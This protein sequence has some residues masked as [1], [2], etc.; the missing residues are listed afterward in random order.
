ME[1]RLVEVDVALRNVLAEVGVQRG[2][3]GVVADQPVTLLDVVEHRLPVDQQP[4]R[5]AEVAVVG[6][7]TFRVHREGQVPARRRVRHLGVGRPRDDRNRL[8]IDPDRDV[9]VAGEQRVDPRRGVTDAEA[10]HLVDV[11]IALVV[12]VRVLRREHADPGAEIPGG[13]AE[14]AGAHEVVEVL[15]AVRHHHRVHVAEVH[16]EVGVGR[17]EV[18]DEPVPVR[19]HVRDDVEPRLDDRV[20]LLAPVTVQRV[21]AVLDGQRLAVVELDAAADLESPGLEI[22]RRVPLGGEIRLGREL[23]RVAHDRAA[24]LVRP[25]EVERG[26]QAVRVQRVVRAVGVPAD[27]HPA[28]LD[29]RVGEHRVRR[30][31]QGGGGG[32]RDTGRSKASRELAPGDAAGLVFLL[33]VLDVLVHC[34]NPSFLV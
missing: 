20:G 12:V 4:H 25:H 27:P 11:R 6:G 8:G 18:D 3:G 33:V 23:G 19:L 1:L 13:E 5:L 2:D 21:D 24:D 26:G 15:E 29:R 10:L 16:R 30:G 17:L 22:V 32:R 7:R 9:D 31:E 34:L 28:A 14:R